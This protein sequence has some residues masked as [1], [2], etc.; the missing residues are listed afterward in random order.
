M[1]PFPVLKKIFTVLMVVIGADLCVQAQQPGQAANQEA[2]APL[3][4]VV[5][6]DTTAPAGWKRY[7]FGDP[8]SFSAIL[9]GAPEYHSSRLAPDK[10]SL[11]ARYYL[12]SNATGVYVLNYIESSQTNPFNTSETE[13][14]IT[15]NK[16]MTGLIK[17]F[18]AA[19]QANG[20]TDLETT[21]GDQRRIKISGFVGYEQD[22]TIGP[23]QGRA[24]VLFLGKYAYV[25]MAFWGEQDPLSE[26]TAFFNSFQ[27]HSRH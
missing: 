4:V 20:L 10:G 27:I 18:K 7:Q 26:R 12:N 1:K 6:E 24:Q 25:A 2:V 23:L 15:F 19:L 3:R 21:M 16:Y 14:T 17:G 5:V 9:P 8:I 13:T 22:L 11:I